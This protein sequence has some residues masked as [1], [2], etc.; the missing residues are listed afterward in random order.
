METIIKKHYFLLAR[1]SLATAL[2][3]TTVLG[4][5]PLEQIPLSDWNDKLQH[6]FAFLVLS[7]LIDASWPNREMD[8]TKAS[9]LLSYGLMLEV[10]QLWPE[11]RFFSLMDLLADAA[12][13]ALYV[14]SVP[15]FKRLP[16]FSWRWTL[17]YNQD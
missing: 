9:L 13:I 15:I 7:F 16:V 14:L 3:V 10:L 12:G 8:W 2:V 5:L 4:L 17:P 1:V 6:I 11:H